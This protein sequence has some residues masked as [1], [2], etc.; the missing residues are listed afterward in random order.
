ML[1]QVLFIIA[2]TAVV[3]SYGA[4]AHN[5]AP[6]QVESSPELDLKSGGSRRKLPT[7]KSCS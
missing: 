6:S 5:D 4:P 1:K 3:S 7:S 2:Q